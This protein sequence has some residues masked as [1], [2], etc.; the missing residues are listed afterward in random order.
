MNEEQRFVIDVFGKGFRTYK[1]ENFV[2]Y[3][4]GK[5][6][7]AILDADLGYSI[8]GIYLGA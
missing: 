4:V 8:L 3:G 5:N 1:N 7:E 2:L 6:T